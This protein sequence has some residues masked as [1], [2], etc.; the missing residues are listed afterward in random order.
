MLSWEVLPPAAYS[1]DLALSDDNLFTSM[2]HPL[3]EQRFS[4][5]KNIFKNGSMNGL[6]Q[7]KIFTGVEFINHL[8]GG[9]NV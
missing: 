8:K 1:P 9:K 2:G 4:S 7:E 3:A 5:Y 6:P